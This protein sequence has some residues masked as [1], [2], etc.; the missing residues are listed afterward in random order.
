MVTNSGRIAY[1][2]GIGVAVAASLLTMWATIVREDDVYTHASLTFLFLVLTAWVGAFAAWFRPAGMARAML[3]VAI[4]QALLIVAIATAPSAAAAPDGLA[5]TY[6]FSGL[7]T[8]LWLVS[9]ALFRGAA[10]GEG[11]AE[12]D[13]EISA[14]SP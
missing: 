9:A 12:S 7:F 13:E 6:R 14:L 4:M 11:G 2:A 3:G 1:R 8:V 5:A 10:R